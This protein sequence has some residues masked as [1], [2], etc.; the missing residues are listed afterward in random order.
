ML[1][2]R[3]D[4]VFALRRLRGSPGYT[5]FA[6]LTLAIA[7]GVTASVYSLVRTGLKPFIAVEGAD[8]LV[9][10]TEASQARM[11]R[12]ARLS[13]LDYEDLAT[14]VPSFDAAVAWMPFTNALAV[15]G[16]A[17]FVAGEYVSDSFF[18]VV[19]AAAMRGR[20]LDT[21]DAI[22]G[23][24]PVAVIS[25]SAWRRY[26][27]ANPAAI[28]RVVKVSGQPF[29]IVG[30]MPESFRGIDRPRTVERPELWL[31]LEAVRQLQ[32]RFVRADRTRRDARW[33][34]VA[35]R[36][37]SGATIE[38]ATVELRQLAGRIDAVEPLPPIG[39]GS[40]AV[41]RTRGWDA[42]GVNEPID[43]SEERAMFRV[44]L[45]L[46][47]LVLLV[48]CTNLANF[49]LSRGIARRHELAVRQAIGASRWQLI[50]GQVIEYGLVAAAGAGAGIFVARQLLD[51]AASTM[52]NLWGTAPQYRLEATL[53][54]PVLMATAGA[55]LLS[56]VV[57]GLLP[58]LSLTKR[59]PSRAIA[60]DQATTSPPRWRGRGNL[61]ALQLSVSVAL[62]LVSALC[63][64]EL[65]NV[66]RADPGIRLEHVGAVVVPFDSQTLPDPVVQRLLEETIRQSASLPIRTASYASARTRVLGA[67]L[68]AT[69]TPF[70]EGP[71]QPSARV[72]SVSPGYLSTVGL[73]LLSGREILDTDAA[74]SQP[75]AMIN[76]TLA[77]NLFGAADPIGRSLTVENESG[78]AW[79]GEPPQIDVT[80]VGTV[81][82]TKYSRGGIEA[83]VYRPFSQRQ[84]KLAPIEILGRARDGVD[85]AL[86]GH[87][88]REALRRANPDIAV[89]FSGRADVQT[90]GQDVALRLFVIW[91]GT[92][93]FLALAFAMSGLY[94][95]LSHVVALRTR[96]LGVRAAL[97]AD[98]GRLIRLVLKDGARPVAEG[99]VI[100][101]GLAAGARLG[102]QPWFEDPITAVDPVAIVIALVPLI[103]AAIVACYL[104][105][106]RAARVDP[107]VALRHL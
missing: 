81:S 95:V 62:L 47:T 69:G 90:F 100:G 12:P 21:G 99:I 98:R 4:L 75:V 10:V 86:A 78:A 56:V 52:R 38:R 39:S 88:L 18:A 32:P 14:Q 49:S 30:I 9:V 25:A 23:A 46:P 96:E 65:P 60:S 53:D 87:Q 45:L 28:G 54:A 74:G 22:P 6:I 71:A 80:V 72:M 5:A 37:R 34:S 3:T 94:G 67:R 92:L 89:T 64:R 61:I 97:G 24:P 66:A 63:V 11:P 73:S 50:R 19:G 68:V 44:V 58:A 31:P 104:P 17:E 48:A 40:S 7:I 106:R 8:R 2:L 102:M 59:S 83:F 13:W 70:R 57:A 33:L 103:A 36:V 79:F 105:A 26:F 107:N 82:D 15:D 16:H 41:P 29:Q 42:S 77:R 76:A 20:V 85:P 91:F 43:F 1:G 84:E 35:G 93:A 101:L 55:G 27:A 51:F